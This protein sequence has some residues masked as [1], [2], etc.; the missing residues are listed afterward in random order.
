[1][2][3][4]PQRNGEPDCRDFLR[5][6][7]CKYGESCKY[8]HPVGGMKARMDP[9]EPPFPIRPNEPLC[10]Y[11]MKNGTCKFGQS[12]KFHH[13]SQ[14]LSSTM[15]TRICTVCPV[16]N[17]TYSVECSQKA[18]LQFLPQ[19]PGE[20]NCTFFMRNGTCKYGATCKF[21]HPTGD[22]LN[23]DQ[24][25]EQLNPPRRGRSVSA[26]AMSEMSKMP[27]VVCASNQGANEDLAFPRYSS[28][29]DGNKQTI[30]EGLLACLTSRTDSPSLT[31]TSIS[32]SYGTNSSTSE[33][34]SLSFFNTSM[35]AHLPSSQ[36][37]NEDPWSTGSNSSHENTQG[38]RAETFGSP[39]NSR[40][41]YPYHYT[42]ET[43]QSNL[44]EGHSQ[45]QTDSRP[46]CPFN[47]AQE[48][49]QSNKGSKKFTYSGNQSRSQLQECQAKYMNTEMSDAYAHGRPYYPANCKREE[50]T[51][52]VRQWN[53]ENPEYNN[54]SCV[55]KTVYS[56]NILP[57]G[58]GHQ[59]MDEQ[60]SMM[61]SSL[62][63]MLDIQDQ[64]T[65]NAPPE[66]GYLSSLSETPLDTFFE[67]RSSIQLKEESLRRGA[68]IH[69]D[70]VFHFE[71]DF[72][73]NHKRFSHSSS[74][75]K[76]GNTG[77]F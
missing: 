64:P 25:N 44:T 26:G 63:S 37:G 15:L 60:L 39:T 57:L 48:T 55:P 2:A 17:E 12:C 20:P 50:S 69:D 29:K 19:R 71:N 51:S 66:T 65:Q 59:K 14:L 8:H 76:M 49:S 43:S 45:H 74:T 38:T 72:E 28:F 46:M 23:S 32:S 16:S 54:V 5:T 73:M 13:P 75:L 41:V 10:Q 18:F 47:Y 27:M 6:G 56:N 68:S 4:Y 67:S 7:R 11:Y 30:E 62:L 9:N 53:L 21:H 36:T 40:P 52:E 77:L 22:A 58:N 33:Q 24:S 42:Q 70:S 31:S 3:N 1:M 61:T 34:E 35:N